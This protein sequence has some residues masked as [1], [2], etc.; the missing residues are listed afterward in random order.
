MSEAHWSVLEEIPNHAI[1]EFMRS[2]RRH[3]GGKLDFIEDGMY[4]RRRTIHSEIIQS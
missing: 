4:A 2:N 1:I 3:T